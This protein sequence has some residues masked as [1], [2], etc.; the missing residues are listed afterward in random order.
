MILDKIIKIDNSYASTCFD[1]M[2]TISNKL[3]RMQNT[4]GD[5]EEQNYIIQLA[6]SLGKKVEE[7]IFLQGGELKKEISLSNKAV[8]DLVKRLSKKINVRDS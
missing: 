4:N 3:E 6:S 7:T 5:I 1:A 2:V 8:Q